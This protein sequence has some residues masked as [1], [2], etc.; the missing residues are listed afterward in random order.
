MDDLRTIA[1]ATSD[2][3]KELAVHSASAPQAN[4][5]MDVRP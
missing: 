3:H 1:L 2:D 4:G 5:R